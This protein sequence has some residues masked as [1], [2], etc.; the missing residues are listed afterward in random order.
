MHRPITSHQW[1]SGIAAWLGW[2][3]DGLD[4]HLYTLVAAPFVAHLLGNL[5]TTDPRVGHHAAIIQA[6]F[7]LGW[8]LG[9]GFFGY[10][11]DRLG[12]ART[13]SLTVLT[14]AA[15]TGL[16]FFAQ[17]W[18]QLMILRF[19][20]ALGI[21]GEWAVGASLLSETWPRKWRPWIAAV[22][23]SGVNIGILG[24]VLANYL[25]AAAEP[26]YL[27]L[28]GVLPAFLVFWIRRAVPEP[29]EWHAA[30]AS[31][32]GQS[33]RIRDLFRGETRRITIWVM[34]VCG[35]SLTAHWAFMFWHQLQ[36][37]NLPDVLA[38]PPAEQSKL[39][40]KAMYFVIGSSILG[41][42]FSGWISR[43]MGYRAAIA[44]TFLVY[45]AVML[46]AYAVPRDHH[47]LLMWFPLIGFCQGVFGLFTMYLPPLFPTLLRT[48][49][50]GFC[51]NIGR[52]AAAFGTV[53]FGLFSTVGDH[54]AALFYAGFLFLPAA[55]AAMLMPHA[56]D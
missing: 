5:P 31:A 11:G 23:Q 32:K 13:L 35:V 12:R 27:F 37:R 10:I 24:A 44:S 25:L 33:P 40:S 48:T 36:L 56:K 21:G 29:A 6:A 51:Y 45:F 7:L 41:N 1:K 15:F 55:G 43:F 3:F 50:A 2:T 49:G 18:W 34:I 52:I 19:L 42:F 20:A 28:V 46:G 53:F 22:L 9:G 4:M 8:A 17:E 26:R 14:Y 38:M 30:K 47:Q 54:R 39:A 16:S